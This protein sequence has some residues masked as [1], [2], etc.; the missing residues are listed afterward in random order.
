MISM[1][2]AWTSL[3][4]VTIGIGFHFSWPMSPSGPGFHRTSSG[5]WAF[6]LHFALAHYRME[7]TMCGSIRVRADVSAM[8]AALNDGRLGSPIAGACV[9]EV[10]RR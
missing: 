8:C 4:L 2:A 10:R 1:R 9:A 6:R 5:R 7:N 3:M